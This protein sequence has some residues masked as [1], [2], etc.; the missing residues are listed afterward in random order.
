[1]K[2]IVRL[3]RQHDLDLIA[4]HKNKDFCLT[5]AIRK[6]LDAYV[7][8]KQLS[9]LAPNSI[10]EEKVPRQIQI[11]VRFDDHKDAKAIEWI[12]TIK[13]GYRNSFIKNLLRGYLTYPIV[14]AYMEGDSFDS[15]IKDN[16][17]LF[18][19]NTI[20][21]CKVK[22]N[23]KKT[24]KKIEK[25]TEP[26]TSVYDEIIHDK[27][28]DTT[29]IE[30]VEHKVNMKEL[31]KEIFGDSKKEVEN[32]VQNEIN[33]SVSNQDNNDHQKEKKSI[34]TEEKKND[35]KKE[36]IGESELSDEENDDMLDMLESM[37]NTF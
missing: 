34:E 36:P 10:L 7:N 19:S 21:Y 15:V 6:S 29:Y 18:I 27:K 22:N 9:I 28:A 14:P 26:K 1:M 31:K 33:K 23:K 13:S 35:I 3:Y 30:N 12:K 2:L 8:K 5:T 20:N 25:D 37:M 32:T 4:L 16:T 17:N 11:I 24:I